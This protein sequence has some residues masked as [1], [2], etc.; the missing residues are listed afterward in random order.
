MIVPESNLVNHW[1]FTGVTNRSEV[2]FAGTRMTQECP[3]SPWERS[4]ACWSVSLEQLR[5]A[6]TALGRGP[7]EPCKLQGSQTCDSCYL[8]SLHSLSSSPWSEWV[9]QFRGRRLQRHFP[10]YCL[11]WSLISLLIFVA[12]FQVHTH[13]CSFHVFH[14]IKCMMDLAQ[15]PLILLARRHLDLSNHLWTSLRVC[16]PLPSKPHFFQ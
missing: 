1:V 15:S 12:A 14:L 5:T 4:T 7:G 11:W 6:S 10:L 8:P 2:L 3:H 9:F 16:L 13:P